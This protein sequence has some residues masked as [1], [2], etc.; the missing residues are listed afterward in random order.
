MLNWSPIPLG[1]IPNISPVFI[2]GVGRS[3]TTPLQLALNMHP[4]LGVYGET[5]AFFVHLKF[6]AEAGEIRLERL[7]KYWGGI[8]T[9]YTPH[10]DLLDSEEM[11]NQLAHAPSYAQVMNLILGAIA[12]RDGKNRWGEKSPAHIFRIAEIRACFPNAQIIHIVRDPRAVACSS[13]KA[14]S[15]GQFTDWNVYGSTRYWLRCFKIHLQQQPEASLGRY[16]LV[17]FEDFV[18]RPEATLQS[19]STFLGIDFAPEMLKAHQTA[20]KYVPMD[21]SGN[22]PA[23]HALTQKPLDASRADAWRRILTPEHAKLVERLAGRQMRTLGYE[24]DSSRKHSSSQV[25]SVYFSA[26]WIA[27]ESRR[28][29][30]KQA[31]PFYWAAQRVIESTEQTRTA[32]PKAPEVVLSQ[33]AVSI[34]PQLPAKRKS[35]GLRPND[36]ADQVRRSGT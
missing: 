13:I 18:T 33:N 9:N 27:S 31:R 34:T 12:A 3:G 28:I 8:V 32:V 4:Q 17:R 35:V 16:L 14:F 36:S 26:R 24:C 19:I 6:G 29:A 11:R 15:G 5:Q 1:S 22:M 20:A 30:N 21:S 2:V 23:L 10:K 7:L 25:N